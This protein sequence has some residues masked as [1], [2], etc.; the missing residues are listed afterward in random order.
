[1]AG[2][3]E[4]KNSK[5]TIRLSPWYYICMCGG[6]VIMVHLVN[7]GDTPLAAGLECAAGAVLG[8]CVFYFAKYIIFAEPRIDKT[9]DE[10]PKT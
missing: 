3:V 8:I 2:E 7:W 5:K 4:S 6:I 9:N 10:K 1:M